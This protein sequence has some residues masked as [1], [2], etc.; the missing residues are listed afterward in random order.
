MVTK[1]QSALTIYALVSSSAKPPPSRWQLLVK[2]WVR[3]EM[4]ACRKLTDV[5]LAKLLAAALYLCG[6]P[7]EP[8]PAF[9]LCCADG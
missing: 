8:L 9:Q 7:V 3:R 4:A 5:C 2:E 6:P 1:F